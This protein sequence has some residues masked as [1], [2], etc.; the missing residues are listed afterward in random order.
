M[1]PFTVSDLV[2]LRIWCADTEQAAVNT[3]WY[4]VAAVG[5]TPATDEDFATQMNTLLAPLYKPV[6]NAHAEYRGT[7]V[8]IMLPVP[9]NHAAYSP[10]FDNSLVGPGTGGADALPRQT[11]GLGSFQTAKPR[12][13]NRG[14]IYYPFPGTIADVGDGSPVAGYVAAIGIITADL[15]VGIAVVAGARTATLVRVLRHGKDKTGFTPPV[16]PVTGS[17]V[18]TKW[19]TQRR[20]GSFGRANS[21]P[22]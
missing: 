7:Q 2:L 13:A 5:A 12:Q 10:V 4:Q 19:A 21:S 14:R 17:T 20:R 15:S 18:A 6:L 16:T 22:I 1:T 8:Q 3:C 11:C 9:P